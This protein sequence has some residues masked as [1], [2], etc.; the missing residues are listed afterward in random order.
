MPDSALFTVADPVKIVRRIKYFALYC[1][2]P[3]FYGDLIYPCGHC[4]VCRQ[5]KKKQWVGRI[6]LE[7][8]QHRDAVFVTL[9][10][11]DEHVPVDAHGVKHVSKDE[12]QRY[13]KRLRKAGLAFRY[14]AVGEYGGRT[15][16]PHYHALLF[17]LGQQHAVTI[18]RCWGLGFTHTG[19]AGV[20]SA[21]YCAH[22]TLKKASKNKFI[23]D[24]YPEFSLASRRPGIGAVAISTLADTF[25]RGP[26]AAY[27][28]QHGDIPLA[29]RHNG[30]R[31]P[32]HPFIADKLR[33]E[34]GIPLLQV[35]R[36]FERHLIHS[37]EAESKARAQHKRLLYKEKYHGV[38]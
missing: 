11:R 20:G 36:P 30:K 37:P 16:R 27:L 13:F 34:L 18:D 29:L 10:Y 31:Y 38:L 12:L 3:T 4:A 2:Y 7:R 15:G 23:P 5:Q 32:M 17:G 33:A 6:L 14:F 21:L 9:T 35:D 19:I 28:E 22:Y 1:A 26:G 25:R 8:S 24:E